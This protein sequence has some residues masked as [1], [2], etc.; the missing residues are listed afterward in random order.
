MDSRQ[1]SR[2]RRPAPTP[3]VALFV[4]LLL[5]VQTTAVRAAFTNNFDAYPVGTRSCLD[6]AST[7]SGCNGDTVTAM[8]DCLCSNTGNFVIGAAECIG[9]S[10]LADLET[11]YTT[12]A[13]ACSFSNT[14]L[15]VSQKDFLAAGNGTYSSSTT[16]MPSTTSGTASAT[17]SLT[18]ITTT[19]NGHTQ[20]ITTTAGTP[21]KT[22]DSSNNDNN[23][24]G[25]MSSTTRT[26]IIAG[27]TVA[28]VAIVAVLAYFLVRMWRK[29]QATEE[30]RP[31]LGGDGAFSDMG[32]GRG[33]GGGGGGSQASGT[34]LSHLSAGGANTYDWKAGAVGGDPSESKWPHDPYNTS[35]SPNL[36]YQ[37]QS[38]GVYELPVQEGAHHP[39]EMPATPMVMA[40]TPATQGYH[41]PQGLQPTEYGQPQ[42]R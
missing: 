11:V 30:N 20:T 15:S 16:T 32:G 38:G 39:V 10:D 36:L 27:A 7:A 12:M 40:A 14:P 5:L 1:Q 29:R 34:E 9:K 22:G 35:P 6:S 28:G 13:S 17:P 4:T 2:R 21:T 23:N 19:S 8:N 3:F 41:H 33:G 31:M 18:T 42:Y 37:Q 24:G 26:G 25:G